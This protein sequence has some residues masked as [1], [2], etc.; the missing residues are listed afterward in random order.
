[1]PTLVRD[2]LPDLIER[3]R[4]VKPY[5]SEIAYLAKVS[6]VTL[7][8]LAMGRPGRMNPRY[9]TILSIAEALAVIE[10]RQQP[11]A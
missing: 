4:V 10:Q 3:L 1:M 8:G 2:I 5:W 7:E 9:A 11:I 6:Y